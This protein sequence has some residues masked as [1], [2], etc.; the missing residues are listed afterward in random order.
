MDPC[1]FRR[2]WVTLKVSV[3][4]ALTL[5]PFDF[6]LPNFWEPYLRP[7]PLASNDQIW[8][9]NAAM[10]EPCFTVG[11]GPATLASVPIF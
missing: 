8:R 6:A 11:H 9:S 7:H 5:V 4:L 3:L 2:P 1:H 10:E